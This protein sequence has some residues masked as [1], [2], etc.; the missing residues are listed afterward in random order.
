MVSDK[1]HARAHGDCQVLTR[2]PLEGRSRDGGLRFGEMERDA[3]L[4][5]GS[6][7]FLNERLLK[8]SDYYEVNVCDKCHQISKQSCCIFCDSDK[9]TRVQMPYAGK[10]LFHELQAMC[11]K[12]DLLTE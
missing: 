3:M 1:M 11:L 2:Q 4:A 7:A 12:I 10:L 5:H 6:S 9:I 8:M